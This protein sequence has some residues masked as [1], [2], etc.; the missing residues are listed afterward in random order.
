MVLVAN[1]TESVFVPTRGID[2]FFGTTKV[3][4][5]IAYL[6]T[7]P[8]FNVAINTGTAWSLR[9]AGGA[10]AI[11]SY[12]SASTTTN[13]RVFTVIARGYVSVG[14]STSEVRRAAVSF[15]YNN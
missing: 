11:A 3:A 15:I 2:L 4:G 12:S 1:C 7:S 14:T 10:T 13:Q 6:G 5:A 9:R 8:Y